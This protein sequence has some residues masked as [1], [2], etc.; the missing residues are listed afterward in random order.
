M[1]IYELD[2]IVPQIADTAWV[3]DSA[4]VMG[5]VVLDSDVGIWFGV[6]VRGD[7]AAIRVGAGTNIQD[8]SVLHADVGT[9]LTIGS[10]V[11]VGHKAM[12]HGCT[13][14]DD[15][16]IGI[17]AVVLNNAKIGKG[18]LV[19]AGALVTEGKEFPDGSMIIGS[20][21]RLV[22]SLTPEELQGLRSSAEHYVV[23]AQR[24]KSTLHKIA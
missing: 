22:R 17:G 12:L 23:N 11:T 14:G 3:A 5:D 6:V 1:A 20:P 24:F 9:P 7:T 13:I 19:G 8:L 21:A 18:C 16:L 2:G 15:S 10:G 4:E